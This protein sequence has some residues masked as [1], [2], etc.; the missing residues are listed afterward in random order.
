MTKKLVEDSENLS[1]EVFRTLKLLDAAREGGE[2]VHMVAKRMGF[3]KHYIKKQLKENLDSKKLV[4]MDLIL[5]ND[6]AN[7]EDLRELFTK[8]ISLRADKEKIKITKASNLLQKSIDK[9]GG[10]QALEKATRT[11]GDKLASMFR[12]Y[13]ADAV[14]DGKD[15]EQITEAITFYRIIADVRMDGEVVAD[16]VRR[17]G[18]GNINSYSSKKH[19]EEGWSFDLEKLQTKIKGTER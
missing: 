3:G 5:A 9:A 4:S 6:Y 11:S 15:E 14:L 7:R 18:L 2:H 16:V 1:E 8:L 12:R 19:L 10:W 13:L 17:L